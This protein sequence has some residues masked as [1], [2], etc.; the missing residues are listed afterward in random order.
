MLKLPLIL[1]SSRSTYLIISNKL[2]LYRLKKDPLRQ[3]GV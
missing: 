1:I 2:K 3:E